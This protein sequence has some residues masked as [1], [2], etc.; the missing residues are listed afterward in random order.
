MLHIAKKG[1]TLIELLVVI[2]IIGILATGGVTVYTTQMAKARDSTRL[3]DIKAIQGAVEQS[4]LDNSRYPDRG[5]A[6]QTA[7]AAFIADLP[8]DPRSSSVSNNGTALDYLYQSFDTTWNNSTNAQRY[9][10][11]VGFEY[12]AGGNGTMLTN[13]AGVAWDDILRYELGTNNAAPSAN[14][15]TTRTA[16]IAAADAGWLCYAATGNSSACNNTRATSIR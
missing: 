2:T 12:A 3:S 8:R 13:D 16:A 14:I 15:V 9:E 4:N 10:L 6:L 5:A 11:S 1:F 7:V